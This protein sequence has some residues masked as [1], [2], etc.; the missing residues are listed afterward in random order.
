MKVNLTKNILGFILLFGFLNLSQAG[1]GTVGGGGGDPLAL[2][3]QQAALRAV[4]NIETH[5]PTIFSGVDLK[6]LRQ[7]IHSAIVVVVDQ[8]PQARLKDLVQDSA[9]INYPE[10]NLILIRRKQYNEEIANREIEEPFSLHEYLS[11]MNLE[12]TGE[13]T[14]SGLYNTNLSEKVVSYDFHE[15]IGCA[16]TNRE[17]ILCFSARK[18]FYW[19]NPELLNPPHN[20]VNPTELVVSLFT[21]CVATRLGIKCWG[22]DSERIETKTK[23]WRQPRSLNLGL[24]YLTDRYVQ[25]LC[26]ITDDG[27]LCSEDLKSSSGAPAFDYIKKLM[28][29]VYSGSCAL[30]DDKISCWGNRWAVG[31]V[32]NIPKDLGKVIDVTFEPGELS[33]CAISERKGLAC[34]GNFSNGY[35]KDIVVDG[36]I[37]NP[38][39][40]NKV[41]M[42]ADEVC[43][44]K[45]NGVFRCW[46]VGH[47]DVDYFPINTGPI[48]DIK[49]SGTNKCVLNFSGKL[50]CWS[51]YKD[52]PS[53]ITLKVPAEIRY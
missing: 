34:W 41:F 17:R 21:G 51:V 6:K 7:I 29:P 33:G 36:S 20:L 14:Y 49:I 25:T 15:E 28:A 26:A 24:T 48:T 5:N 19:A 8:L 46:G 42:S 37:E 10:E 1:A 50:R 3:F 11:L 38:T 18:E 2:Q 13:Y 16:L 35:L 4:N 30:A 27:P 52:D 43:A 23:N 32:V 39:S 45:P 53:L 22:K 9:V 31:T 47:H 12:R 40:Y 44:I